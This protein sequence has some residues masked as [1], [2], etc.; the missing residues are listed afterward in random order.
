M[1]SEARIFEIG[2]N[3]I[4][5]LSDGIFA[6]VMTLF[7]LKE[8]RRT[9]WFERFK[10][11]KLFKRFRSNADYNQSGAVT[12]FNMGQAALGKM[13]PEPNLVG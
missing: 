5:A 7:I 1:S 12:P 4:E 9:A 11:A 10:M 3:R 13:R 8:K 6:I 2:K